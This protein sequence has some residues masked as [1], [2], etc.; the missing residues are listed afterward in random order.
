MRLAKATQNAQRIFNA[1]THRFAQLHPRPLRKRFQNWIK[2]RKAARSPL[3]F[4]YRRPMLIGPVERLAERKLCMQHGWDHDLF[5]GRV[6]AHRGGSAACR[7]RHPY[8][9]LF[10]HSEI[11]ALRLT[12]WQQFGNS[13]I[14]LRNVLHV[15][16][17]LNVRIIEFAQPHPFFM[18]KRVGSLRFVDHGP[19]LGPTIES[20]FFFVDAFHL[21]PDAIATS[22]LFTHYIRPLLVPQVSDVD[23]RVSRQD[24]VL[25]FRAGDVFRPSKPHPD[26][27]Q[28]PLSFY[29]AAVERECPSRVWLVFENRDNPCVSAVESALRDRGIEVMPQSG[30]LADDIK[31]LLSG[32][33]VV[34]SRGSFVYMISHLSERLQKLYLFEPTYPFMEREVLPR[35]GVQVVN[36]TD[37]RGVYK[38]KVL[39][40]WC[41]SSEQRELLLSYSAE[42][43]A[44][45]ELF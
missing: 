18:P 10:A 15:A 16:E 13:V 8:S 4:G 38:A 37:A 19:A 43:L 33:R 29:L 9:L 26:Y 25:H 1:T 17:K 31:V 6:A 23:P 5:T 14:Q 24:L 35:L 44:F 2:K 45:R 11:K 7:V 20:S 27:G 3:R 32:R 34:A 40:R 30:T 12:R 42:N 22:R 36:V 39:A 28:P 21:K 41:G